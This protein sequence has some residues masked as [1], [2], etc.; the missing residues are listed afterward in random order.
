MKNLILTIDTSN[1]A[2]IILTLEKTKGF[3]VVKKIKAARQQ[4][5]KLLI[6]VEKL[7]ASQAA[8]LKDLQKIKV[9][10]FGH[11][12]TSLRIGV[13]TANA[14]G[15]ALGIPVEAEVV[16][17]NINKSLKEKRPKKIAIAKLPAYSIVKPIYDREANIGP[18]KKPVC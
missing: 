4:S 11:S 17:E 13:I 5:E 18:A 3:K 12:F 15:Y 9:V 16:A 2:E 8:T 1:A 6:S 14:L 7:L 10:N